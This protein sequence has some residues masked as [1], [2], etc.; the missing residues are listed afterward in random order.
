VRRSRL[1]GPALAIVAAAGLVG[2]PGTAARAAD[3]CTSATSV[4]VHLP[5][6][7]IHTVSAST[8]CD[9]SDVFDTQY[10]TRAVPGRAHDQMSPYVAQGTSIRALLDDLSPSVD[11][12]SVSFVAIPRADGTWTTL[13]RA[14]IGD[15]SDFAGN[16][17]PVLVANGNLMNYYRPLYPDRDD[18]N[19]PDAVTSPTNGTIE[20][21]VHSGSLLSVSADASRSATRRGQPVRFAAHVSNPPPSS[22]PLSYSWTFGDGATATGPTVTHAFSSDGTY[23]AQVT[24]T[25]SDDSGG[26]SNQIAETVGVPPPKSG[27]HGQGTGSSH[28]PHAPSTGPETGGGTRAG[29]RPTHHA[30]DGHADSGKS[31]GGGAGDGRLRLRLT[32]PPTSSTVTPPA[33]PGQQPQLASQSPEVQGRLIGPPTVLSAEETRPAHLA[34]AVAAG[35]GTGRRV[36]VG[37]G[38]A[39][40]FLALFSLG[41]IRELGWSMPRRRRSSPGPRP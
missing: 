41:V 27:H 38:I 37:V 6:R 29:G 16:L 36:G 15:P 39:A 30:T 25:G 4:V 1:T 5:D 9:E 8:L 32:L 31:A 17:L 20:V 18:V 11:P 26:V 23:D 22:Q 14:D 34:T 12:S 35:L 24:V 19:A 7:S 13:D 21:D 10:V 33:G 2:V 3:P 28:H 40:G